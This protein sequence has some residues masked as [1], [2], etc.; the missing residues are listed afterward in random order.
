MDCSNTRPSLQ[1]AVFLLVL[2]NENLN[3]LVYKTVQG[4]PWAPAMS[5]LSQ[6]PLADLGVSILTFLFPIRAHT[7]VTIPAGRFLG[8]SPLCRGEP[9][10]QTEMD[11][12][13]LPAKCSHT[14]THVHTHRCRFLSAEATPTL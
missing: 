13:S 7:G 3:E 11:T 12:H 14:V 10:G 9:K 5:F 6:H 4:Q 8:L 1:V 2:S